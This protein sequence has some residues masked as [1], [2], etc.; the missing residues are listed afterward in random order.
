MSIISPPTDNLYKFIAISGLIIFIFGGVLILQDYNTE[1]DLLIKQWEKEQLL[2]SDI[3]FLKDELD[4]NMKYVQ[5]SDSIENKLGVLLNEQTISDSVSKSIVYNLPDSVKEK[6][7]SLLHKQAELNVN[8]NSI[9][10]ITSGNFNHYLSVSLLY[11]GEIIAVFGF[12][13]WYNMVQKPLDDEQRN[14]LNEDLIDGNVSAE[15]CQSCFKTFFFKDEFGLEL[16]GTINKF[17]CKECYTKGVFVEP[18]LTYDKAKNRL[19]QKL[20]SLNYNFIQRYR[21]QR[22][23]KVA[24]RWRRNQIW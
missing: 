18:E 11:I 4:F 6:F 22:K 20:K 14:K 12:I 13:L 2:Q 23:F 15:N 24:L 8:R 9:D 5:L 3:S 19:K 10:Y 16:D 7:I 17:F 1:K 21:I